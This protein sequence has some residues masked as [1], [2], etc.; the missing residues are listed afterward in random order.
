MPDTTAR[1]FP[2][3]FLFGAA[4]AAYQIE[5][6]AHEDGRR[7]SIW[8]VFTKVPG[9][10]INGEDGEIACDHYHLYQDDVALMASLGLQTYRF[11]TSWSRV[12]PDGGALN[13]KGVD[14]YK[15]LVD[16]VRRE[17][18]L[19]YLGEARSDLTE[20]AFLVGYSE[21]SAFD[22]AFRRWTGSTP[23]QYRKRLRGARVSVAQ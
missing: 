17:L 11:S 22:R 10:V 14:F 12:R 13:P 18:A 5:G 3:G 2:P 23:Q 8:D 4:A 7:D 6:A 1:E 21:L 16:D 19:R 9:A 15:R 20:I